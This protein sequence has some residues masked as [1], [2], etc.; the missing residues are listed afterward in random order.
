MPHWHIEFWSN[1]GKRVKKGPIEK[2]L[3]TLTREQLVSVSK[4]LALLMKLGNEL[5]LPHSRAL[6][7]SLFELRER[8]FGYRLYYTFCDNRLIVVVASGDKKVRKGILV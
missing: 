5:R 7:S 4:E 6:G 1:T 2:W 3:D 8:K